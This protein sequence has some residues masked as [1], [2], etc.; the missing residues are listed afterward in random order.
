M[1]AVDSK[2]LL[3]SQSQKPGALKASKL[4]RQPGRCCNSSSHKPLYFEERRALTALNRHFENNFVHLRSSVQLF[5]VSG[6]I[7]LNAPRNDLAQ[8]SPS[9]ATSLFVRRALSSALWTSKTGRGGFVFK[10]F[11][12]PSSADPDGSDGSENLY[13][14]PTRRRP[15]DAMGW[16]KQENLHHMSVSRSRIETKP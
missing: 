9:P 2:P 11:T 14:Q 10:L 13:I 12:R 4:L 1:N 3:R 16:L 6:L 8:H 15:V 7:R 5:A